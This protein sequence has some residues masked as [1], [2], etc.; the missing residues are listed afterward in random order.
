MDKCVLI[1]IL[2]YIILSLSE[3]DIEKEAHNGKDN[4]QDG[5]EIIEDDQ[6]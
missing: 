2:Q 6:R 1:T 4:S 5:K 3:D